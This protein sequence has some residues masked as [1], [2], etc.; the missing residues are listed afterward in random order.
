MRGQIRYIGYLRLQGQYFLHVFFGELSYGP[1][2]ALLHLDIQRYLF[3]VKFSECQE[4]RY[5]ST[6]HLWYVY[7]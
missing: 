2:L 5:L 7:V 3:V 1:I 6:V 4:G